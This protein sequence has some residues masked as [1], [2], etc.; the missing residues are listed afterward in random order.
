MNNNFILT[1]D[2]GC[3]L[4]LELCQKNN[5][6]P[7]HLKYYSDQEENIDTMNENDSIA[8]YNKMRKGVIFKTSQINIEEFIEFFEPMLTQNLPILHICMGSAISG[9]FNNGLLAVEKLKEK[10]PNSQI[11][12]IDSTLASVGYGILALK[13]A[14]FKAQGK[15]VQECVKWVEENK[16][17]INTYYTTSTL[18]YLARSGRM[19]S[20]SAVIGKLLAVNPILKLDKAGSLLACATVLGKKGAVK[21]IISK[22]SEKITNASEQTLY[23]SHSD[24][25]EEAKIFGE[26]LKEHFGFKDVLYTYIGSTIGTHAGPGIKT[27]FFFGKERD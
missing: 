7:I 26:T 27:A 1:T 22:I 11:Y 3:D 12:F 21:K 6:T 17:K 4:S 5:I 8:F 16:A 23:V 2:S 25:P 9:T 15:T 13:V 14:E 24:I 19:K 20:T 18:S 10:Y